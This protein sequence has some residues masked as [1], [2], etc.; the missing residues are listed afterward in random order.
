MFIVSFFTENLFNQVKSNFRT[1]KLHLRRSSISWEKIDLSWVNQ[2]KRILKWNIRKS[3]HEFEISMYI[4]KTMSNFTIVQATWG[5]EVEVNA[6]T[7]RSQN[8]DLTSKAMALP[9]IVVRTEYH[10]FIDCE[11]ESSGHQ[12]IQSTW[13]RRFLCLLNRKLIGFWHL[14]VILSCKVRSGD[15][16]MTENT[17]QYSA[18][19]NLKQFESSSSWVKITKK[20]TKVPGQLWVLLRTGIKVLFLRFQSREDNNLDF[21]DCDWKKS[22]SGNLCIAFQPFSLQKNDSLLCTCGWRQHCKMSLHEVKTAFT[23]GSRGIRTCPDY[24]I[25]AWRV[26]TSVLIQ[27]KFYRLPLLGARAWPVTLLTCLK[28]SFIKLLRFSS[29]SEAMGS[30]LWLS[31]LAPSKQHES[32][33]E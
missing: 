13:K 10:H 27:R 32:L 33:Q 25:R 7:I 6:A 5:I 11:K 18:K 22:K 29:I 15:D 1:C 28:I 9:S 19:E 4:H 3:C 20:P 8:N 2:Q 21:F 31:W 30:I 26:R 17:S 23:S 16:P 24:D 12:Q 14:L